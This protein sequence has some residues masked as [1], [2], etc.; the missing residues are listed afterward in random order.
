M[1]RITRRHLLIG[2]AVVGGIAATGL[3]VGTG[4]LATRDVE[5]LTPGTPEAGKPVAL[6]GWI[7]IGTDGRVRVAV[8]HLEMGQGITT[9][10]AM[11]AAE[12]LELPVERIV[13][14]HPSKPQS[15]HANFAVALQKRPEELSGLVDWFGQRFI[16]ALELV[17]TG[18]S[19]A[20]VNAWVPLRRAAAAA[21]LMLEEAG[22][23]TLGVDRSAVK[24]VDG[25]IVHEATGRS[26]P[27]ADLAVAAAGLTP[28]S[29]IPLKRP[30]N[31]RVIGRDTP[32]LDVPAK[33]DGSAVF[34]SDVRLPGMLF[35]RLALPDLFGRRS[36]RPIARRRKRCRA[37]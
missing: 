33:V 21:R 19:T 37:W 13:A 7:Q 15:F 8:P 24:A 22:A 10:L 20:T 29:D 35:A 6:N 31:W 9:G 5:G 3:L 17:L 2:G 18:G 26:V 16:G 12:E 14:Y 4:Y 28:P 36:L 27:Y 25:A 11:L 34:A 32:R 30:E 1:A 23:R